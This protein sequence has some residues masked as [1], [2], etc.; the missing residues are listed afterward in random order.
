MER[1]DDEKGSN[2]KRA[3]QESYQKTN[4]GKKKK[5]EVYNRSVRSW[6]D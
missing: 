3:W 4:T 2:E 1:V 5:D 6:K